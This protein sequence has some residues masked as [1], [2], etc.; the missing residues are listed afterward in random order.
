MQF[1]ASHEVR[2]Q[3]IIRQ[4]ERVFQE[5]TKDAS[6]LINSV[7]SEENTVEAVLKRLEDRAQKLNVNLSYKISTKVDT[8][9]QKNF[10]SSE[11][12]SKIPE[13]LRAKLAN[14][15]PTHQHVSNALVDFSPP[16]LKN[17]VEYNTNEKKEVKRTSKKELK[18][19]SSPGRKLFGV[20]RTLFFLPPIR[21]Q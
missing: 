18:R 16:T 15:P 5:V 7:P 14:L 13:K 1:F 4:I 20:S 17:S 2:K 8:N 19:D 10:A 21:S 12:Q 3:A 6:S 11:K 9:A